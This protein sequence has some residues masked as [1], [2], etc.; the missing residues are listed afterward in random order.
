M[1][2]KK[3]VDT[4]KSIKAPDT[5]RQRVALLEIE[6]KLSEQT[7]KK[8]LLPIAVSGAAACFLAVMIIGLALRANSKDNALIYLGT[9]IGSDPVAIR[10]EEAVAS[11]GMSRV[12]QSGIPLELSVKSESKVSVSDGMLFVY[13]SKSGE[14]ISVVTHVTLSD[15]TDIRWDV[16][17]IKT[18]LP[19]LYVETKNERTV[20]ALKTEDDEYFIYMTSSQ[21]QNP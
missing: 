13:D 8:R 16:S 19:E 10:S 7:R 2:D 21:P 3:T 20:Y 6:K 1:F 18:S 4:Y 5:L 9:V 14:L 17:K 15:D 12:Y 11:F